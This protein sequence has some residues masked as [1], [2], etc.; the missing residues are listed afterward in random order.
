MSHTEKN[1][2]GFGFFGFFFFFSFSLSFRDLLS[3]LVLKKKKILYKLYE[4]LF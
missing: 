2:N 3:S 1:T 4:G